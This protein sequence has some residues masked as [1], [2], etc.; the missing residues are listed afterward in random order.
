MSHPSIYQ[1]L[2]DLAVI[3]EAHPETGTLIKPPWLKVEKTRGNTLFQIKQDLRQKQLFT[4][5]EEAKCP[6]ISDCWNSGTATFMILGDTCTRGCRF[7]HVRTGNP[8][9]LLDT[10]EPLK[11][12]QT[13]QKMQLKYAVITMVD[14]DDL[15]DGGARHI[16][17][18]ITHIQELNPHTLIE[19]LAGDFRGNEAALTQVIQSGKGINVFAHNL[20]TIERLTPR[21]RDPRA[22]YRQSLNVLRKAKS[23]KPHLYTKSS[24]MLGLGEELPEIQET[25]ND[26]KEYGV[27]IVTFGQYLQPTP[28][29]LTVKRFVHPQ[30]FAYWQET[31]CKMG[32]KA[33][34]SGPLIRSSYKAGLLFPGI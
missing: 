6:N 11:V 28:K 31:A 29:H 2:S 7:C 24:L 23:L 34:A 27:D 21:V 5:C 33:V 26:L 32:F 17:Q 15:P 30:E 14:R 20:E 8:E 12:A 16:S 19:I 25:L 13:I 3:P 22:K 4:V 1:T 9:G 18:T 10:E